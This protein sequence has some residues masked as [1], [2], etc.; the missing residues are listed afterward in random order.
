[1]VL[2][3]AFLVALLVLCPPRIALL[4]GDL[5]GLDAAL[6]LEEVDQL[7][8]LPVVLLL[9]VVLLPDLGV[10]ATQPS[11]LLLQLVQTGPLS[12]LPGLVLLVVALLLLSLLGFLGI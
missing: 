6:P 12:L 8:L 9:L 1:M 7:L 5:P 11:D 4:V 2:L 3:L 10:V